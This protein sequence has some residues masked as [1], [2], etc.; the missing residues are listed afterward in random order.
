MHPGSHPNSEVK[1]RWASSVLR[2]GTT[3]EKLGVVYVFLHFQAPFF[4]P[5]PTSRLLDFHGLSDLDAVWNCCG[6]CSRLENS[7]YRFTYITG[8]VVCVNALSE[9]IKT[10]I[11]EETALRARRF[12]WRWTRFNLLATIKYYSRCIKYES[13]MIQSVSMVF[14]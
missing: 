4:V 6:H 1:M 13:W 5:P 7:L 9:W 8:Y 14:I 3:R 2:W 10:Q 12:F 11:L